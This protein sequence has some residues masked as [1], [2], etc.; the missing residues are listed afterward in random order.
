MTKSTSTGKLITVLQHETDCFCLV[1]LS[2][3]IKKNCKPKK[4]CSDKKKI[5]KGIIDFMEYTDAVKG[6]FIRFHGKLFTL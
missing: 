6:H 4:A 5:E 3:G 1:E 2:G